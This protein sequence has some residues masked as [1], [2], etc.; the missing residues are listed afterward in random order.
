MGRF[1]C[2][3]FVQNA[4][5]KLTIWHMKI[6]H[7]NEGVKKEAGHSWLALYTL[8]SEFLHGRKLGI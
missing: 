2:N 7:K 1:T 5:W 6:L 3:L 4:V 8:M